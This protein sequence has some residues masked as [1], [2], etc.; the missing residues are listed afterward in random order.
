MYIIHIYTY[1]YIYEKIYRFTSIH[2]SKY[3]YQYNHDIFR[4]LIQLTIVI[5][6]EPSQLI[7]LTINYI[8]TSES[9]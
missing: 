9:L 7:D 8:C 1:T 3:K 5:A 2:G 4:N 6:F